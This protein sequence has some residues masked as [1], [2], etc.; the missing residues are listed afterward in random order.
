MPKLILPIIAV[1]P[2]HNNANTL[3]GLLEELIRQ[4]YSDIYVIDDASTDDTVK[5]I[6]KYSPKVKLIE[7]QKNV[8]SGANRNR[9]I[10]KTPP[11]ILHF[12]DADMRLLTQK[13]PE[14]IRQ[15]EWPKNAAFIGG[16]IRNP[17]GSQNPFNFGP[18]PHI[19]TGIFQGGLQFIIW[20]IGR[21]SWQVGKFLR[22]LFSPLLKGLPNIY[23][24]QHPQR[25]HWAAESNMLVK[26][27]EFAKHGGY[28][29]RF[30]YSEIADFAL[31]IHRKG[32]HGY[33]NPNID[34][35]HDSWDNVLKSGNKRR[36]AH[37]K[38]LEKHGRLAY[39]L[40]P[41]S[42]YLAGRKTQKRYH[43]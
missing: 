9:I 15:I 35:L 11:A 28:D 40:P 29:P 3:P 5:V 12:I 10:G 17:D 14:I 1:V 42:D 34:A 41:L 16:L 36:K 6:Q 21:L 23:T 22:F 13:S 37:K 4:S 24:K 26:S 2:A 18:R 38:F 32:Q 25:V 19:I 20:A 43:K 27:E 8:G 30:K 39:Y 31:R 33:F 7:N